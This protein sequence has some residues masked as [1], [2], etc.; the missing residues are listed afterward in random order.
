MSRHYPGTGTWM[1][2]GQKERA[3][4][5]TDRANR[6]AKARNESR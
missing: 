6:N 2:E 1:M 3:K 4:G 5:G